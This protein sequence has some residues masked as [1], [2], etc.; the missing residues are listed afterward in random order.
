M[1][2]CPNCKAKLTCGCQK[3]VSNKGIAGCAKCIAGLNVNV[4]V[5]QPKT[6]VVPAPKASTEIKAVYIGPGTQI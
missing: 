2:Y 3:R 1:S 5:A 4:N 6:T